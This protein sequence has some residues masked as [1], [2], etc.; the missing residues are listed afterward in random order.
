MALTPMTKLEAV[1]IMLL[2]I[3]EQP[4]STLDPGSITQEASIAE[5]VLDTVSRDVQALGWYFNE[6]LEVTLSPDVDDN[7]AIPSDALKVIPIGE[8]DAIGI[9]AGYLY[10]RTEGTDE[11]DDDVDCYIVYGQDFADLPQSAKAYIAIRAARVF[12]QRVLGS[13]ALDK[14]SFDD[15]NRAWLLLQQDEVDNQGYNM[16][17]WNIRTYRNL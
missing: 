17:D 10:N 11:F 16:A 7:I 5:D 13:D 4:V 15:E 6:T 8:S 9:R 3:G 2:A 14:Y 1:N 12:Q